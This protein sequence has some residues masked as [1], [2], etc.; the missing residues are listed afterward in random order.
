MIPRAYIDAWRAHAP[1]RSDAM[2]EQDLIICRSMSAI[3]LHPALAEQ[4]LFRGGT[5]LHKLFFDHPRRYSEDIDLVQC[6]PGPIGP[7]FDALREAL[8]PLL[9]RPQ[10][11]R[12][13]GVATLTFRMASEMPPVIPM[14]LKVEINTREHFAAM[15]IEKRRFTMASPWFTGECE[16]PTYRL[17]ELLATKLRALYQRRKGRDIYDLWLGLTEG[18]AD[19]RQVVGVFKKYLQASGAEISRTAFS[20]NLE[21]KRRHPGFTADLSNL[22]PVEVDFDFATGFASIEREI[23]PWI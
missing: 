3:F 4:L 11:K 7:A 8:T 10:R 23:L 14:K 18:G 6:R 5:A 21:A 12:G 22:L 19:G 16:V 20:A 2:V 17:E 1:W 13:P 9:G 15:G